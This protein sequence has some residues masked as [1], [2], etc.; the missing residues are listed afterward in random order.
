M[1]LVSCFHKRVFLVQLFEYLLLKIEV[2]SQIV[3]V[4]RW[5]RPA[6]S[7]LRT[8]FSGGLGQEWEY[9]FVLVL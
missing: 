8:S 7:M 4:A 2:Q 6:I 3:G 1:I 5:V 9:D